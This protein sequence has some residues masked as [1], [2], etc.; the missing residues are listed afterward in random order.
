MATFVERLRNGQTQLG[1]CVMY[2]AAGIIEGVGRDWDW[3]WID[4]Q[5]GQFGYTD[6]LNAV[7]AC[8]VMGKPAFIRVAGHEAGPIG[9]ALDCA[10]TGIIVP[11]VDTPEQAAAVVR[12]AKFPPLGNRSYGGRRPVD[13]GGRGYSHTANQDTML[14]CQ[15]E[16]PEAIENAP[17]IAAM[18]GVDG[19]F[20]GPDDITLRRGCEMTGPR[21]ME[22]L[23]KDMQA[24]AD[25]CREYGK[26]AVIPAVGAERQT[27]ARD[28]GFGMIVGTADV[29][30]L[31][32]GSVESAKAAREVIAAES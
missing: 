20:L 8:D 17:A 11:C 27:L 23:T 15:I 29:V 21:P 22:M 2:P 16:S 26:I 7:R 6:L 4:G 14:I 10:A 25:A 31:R 3:F 13:L 9:M 5:H 12:A 28:M 19:L 32:T 1:F 24:V 30:L 18:P